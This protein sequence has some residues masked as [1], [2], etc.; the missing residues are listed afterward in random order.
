MHVALF[1]NDL[2]DPN[3]VEKKL[4]YSVFLKSCF[5]LSCGRATLG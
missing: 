5:E 3:F 2:L 1:I 4:F